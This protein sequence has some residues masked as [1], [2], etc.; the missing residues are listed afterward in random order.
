MVS[1]LGDGCPG[2]LIAADSRILHGSFGTIVQIF[3][4]RL[5][6]RMD[7]DVVVSRSRWYVP[8]GGP[9]SWLLAVLRLIPQPQRDS[10]N[11]LGLDPGRYHSE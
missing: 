9:P 5:W 1:R 3:S 11:V 8:A 6:M 7:G 4:C 2:S 10:K